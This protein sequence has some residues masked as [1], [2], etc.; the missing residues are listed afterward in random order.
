MTRLRL[1]LACWDYDRT[2]ALAD[3]SILPDGI[4]LTYLSLPVEETFFRMLR[5]REFDVAEMSLSSYAVSLM[6]K[7]P[8]FIAIPVFPSRFFRHSCIFVAAK[9][10]IREAKDLAGKRIGTPEYQM[11]APVWIRGI[12]QDEYGLDPAS[13]EYLT[14][15]E[16]EPGREE[17]LKLDLPAKFKV[18]RIGAQQTL[19]AMLAAGEIDA[20]HTARAPSTYRTQPQAVKRL[21]EEYVAVERA[22]FRKTRIFPI[23]HTVVLRRELYRA[24]PWIAQSLQKAFLLAQRKTYD[25]LAITAALKTMLPWQIAHVEEAR[26]ELGEDWWAYGLEPNRH[27]LDTFLRYHHEQGLSQRRLTP[28]ELFAPETLEG[29]KI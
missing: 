12:L 5:Y 6:Q 28:D 13:C 26:R 1:T 4:D 20:L 27:V 18:K 19:S 29:F 11:T 16:E 2:R 8:P 24:H 23:M 7:E 21:F 14:G 15:G 3:G 25:D 10:G 9:S 22:Y 17:K